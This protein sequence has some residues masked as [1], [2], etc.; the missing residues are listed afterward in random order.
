M[1]LTW[2]DPPSPIAAQTLVSNHNADSMIAA[3][4]MALRSV[5]APS[6]SGMSR[7][8]RDKEPSQF[9][10]IIM[11]ALPAKAKKNA[12]AWRPTEPGGQ[13]SRQ[14]THLADVPATTTMI[15]I[16]DIRY[17]GSTLRT[18]GAVT[19]ITANK[20]VAINKSWMRNCV[21]RKIAIVGSVG[22]YLR[23]VVVHIDRRGANARRHRAASTRSLTTR[24]I[25]D[26]ASQLVNVVKN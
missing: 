24:V 26:D 14:P 9:N 12:T 17:S 23:R 7:I 25:N 1:T 19:V 11:A 10:T 6:P 22:W 4:K 13:Q 8:N 2:A 3:V 16:I 5:K 18:V 15:Q 21:G 20:N